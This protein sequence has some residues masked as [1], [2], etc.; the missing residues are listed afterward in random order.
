[1]TETPNRRDMLKVLSTT[2]SAGLALTFVGSEAYAAVSGKL[3]PTPGTDDINKLLDRHSP[4]PEP[5]EGSKVV[6]RP[7]PIALDYMGRGRM[8][9]GNREVYKDM[10]V[11]V[12][13]DQPGGV[14]KVLLKGMPVVGL[15]GLKI[16][17]Y[18]TLTDA[19]LK[20]HREFVAAGNRDKS[21]HIDLLRLEMLIVDS[22]RVNIQES[23]HVWRLL[24]RIPK[25][26]RVERINFCQTP[27]LLIEAM[28]TIDCNWC[29]LW[30]AEGKMPAR[31]RHDLTLGE[32]QECLGWDNHRLVSMMF[33]CKEV[34][35]QT[36]ER[37]QVY[38]YEQYAV[39]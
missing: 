12:N 9:E 33:G 14:P 36:T 11:M 25:Q 8:H 20:V 34:A 27:D 22:P 10:E 30:N 5:S 1:M 32:G 35:V 23:C 21:P 24:N 18:P 16:V 37:S 6:P 26:F 13:L 28:V 2:V 3:P 17:Q 31:L 15:Q 4:A 29:M 19:Q 39:A 7:E 38:D